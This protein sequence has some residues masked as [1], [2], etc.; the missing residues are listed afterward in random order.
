MCGNTM[1]DGSDKNNTMFWKCRHCGWSVYDYHLDTFE[2]A[3]EMVG[4]TI[5]SKI[6]QAKKSRYVQK[7]RFNGYDFKKADKECKECLGRGH[8][9]FQ[10]ICSR[11]ELRM[12]ILND[13]DRRDNSGNKAIRP[14]G[15]GTGEGTK[16][17]HDTA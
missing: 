8:L 4:L 9:D 15:K 11:C 14:T 3:L 5:E 12:R 7:S 17:G 13:H 2:T 10:K 16:N 1:V 6:E